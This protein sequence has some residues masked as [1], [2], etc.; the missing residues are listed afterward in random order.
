MASIRHE[1]VPNFSQRAVVQ[2]ASSPA[3]VI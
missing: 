3:V 1:K 2:N